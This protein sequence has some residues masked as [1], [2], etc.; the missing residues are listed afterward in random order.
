MSPALW[1][2]ER[3]TETVGLRSPDGIHRGYTGARCASR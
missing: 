2:H 3:L 1:R